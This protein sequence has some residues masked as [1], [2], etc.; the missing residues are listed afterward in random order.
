MK[1]ILRNKLIIP[2]S[3]Y[4]SYLKSNKLSENLKLNF[5]YGNFFSQPFQGYHQIGSAFYR[6]KQDLNNINYK[7]NF[8]KIPNFIKK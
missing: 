4:V 1:N 2:T 6:T 5:S 7:E 8:E 3:G